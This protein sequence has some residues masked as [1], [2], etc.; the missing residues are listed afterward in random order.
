MDENVR[1]IIH[2]NDC[3]EDVKRIADND[4]VWKSIM[5]AASR[6]SSQSIVR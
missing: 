6:R 4:G 5:S 3:E 1:C 2:V